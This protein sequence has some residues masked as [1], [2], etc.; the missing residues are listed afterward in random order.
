VQFGAVRGIPEQ[1]GA[2]VQRLRVGWGARRVLHEAPWKD[3]GGGTLVLHGQRPHLAATIRGLVGTG[4]DAPAA[5]LFELGSDRGSEELLENLR[6]TFVRS[7]HQCLIAVG[8][9]AVLDLAKRVVARLD[10]DT[11]AGLAFVAVPTTAGSGS[12]ATR[13]ATVFTAQGK[14]SIEHPRLRPDWAVVDPAFCMSLGTQQRAVA[15]LDALCHL[16]ESQWSLRA[17]PQSRQW[18]VAG[19]EVLDR[20]LVAAVLRPGRHGL[21][22]LSAAAYC[23]GRAIDLSRTTAAHAFSYYLTGVLRIPH[24]LAVATA[25]AGVIAQL[26][27]RADDAAS[28]AALQVLAQALDD[29]G[30]APA[31]TLHR[32]WSRLLRDLGVLGTPTGERFDESVA[33]TWVN[34][35]R[36]ANHPVT[37]DVPGLCRRIGQH[38][39]GFGLV[40]G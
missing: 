26:Q 25:M 19:L 13:F 36:L 3:A 39:R 34:Q 20:S 10:E 9:G 38:A 37:V 24:G 12:E 35:D 33:Q 18:A 11:R 17:S 40:R 1:R 5:V 21:E 14:H 4:R 16:I 31:D 28:R 2:W 8:G 22:R 23:A 27:A 6:R 15:A 30:A 32:R 7:R 29:V